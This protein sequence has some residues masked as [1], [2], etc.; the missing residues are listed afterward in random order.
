M[1]ETTK[2]RLAFEAYFRLGAQRSIERLR[3]TL[4]E[5]DDRAP[6]LRTL[7][8]WS[9][10]YQWQARLAR[11]EHEARIAEAEVLIAAIREMHERHAKAAVFMQEKGLD[12]LSSMGLDNATVDGAIKAIVEGAKLESLSRGE[13]TERREVTG[14]FEARFSEFSDDEL[15]TI[16]EFAH[17][18][19]ERADEAAAE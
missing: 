15:E 11:L 17:Q 16:V 13:P 9:R 5:R 12:W 4:V 3:E 14:E 2:H 7:F 18:A 10:K 6:A 8:D 1:S 19:L